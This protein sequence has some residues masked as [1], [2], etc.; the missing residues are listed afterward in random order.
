MEITIRFDPTDEKQMKALRRFTGEPPRGAPVIFDAKRNM[1]KQ[2]LKTDNIKLQLSCFET[3]LIKRIAELYDLKPGDLTEPIPDPDTAGISDADSDPEP[4]PENTAPE[5]DSMGNPWDKRI[6][7]SSKVRLANGLG[8]WRKRRGVTE[9][10]IERVEAEL[11]ARMNGTADTD[12]PEPEPE[13][14]TAPPPPPPQ[15]AGPTGPT[16][17]ADVKTFK[18]L[19]KFAEVCGLDSVPKIHLVI[20]SIGITSILDAVDD[21]EKIALIAKEFEKCL[22]QS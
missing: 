19:T 9:E 8:I 13:P 5:I 14:D 11:T 18:D 22:T 1:E 7:S 6:H 4:E 17:A 2:A 20:E 3:N 16:C 12:T 10:E 15:L 21:P